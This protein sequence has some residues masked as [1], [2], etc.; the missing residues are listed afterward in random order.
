MVSSLSHL[1]ERMKQNKLFIVRVFLCQTAFVVKKIFSSIT[2][3]FNVR[4]KL[5]MNRNLN[6]SKPCCD[7]D[8]VHHSR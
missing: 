6:R 8:L 2:N 4:K 1:I 3:L 7:I 5:N